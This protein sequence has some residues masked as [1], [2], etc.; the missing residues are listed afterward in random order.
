MKKKS[1]WQSPDWPKC[2]N[3]EKHAG[4]SP[5]ENGGW[6]CQACKDAHTPRSR[7]AYRWGGIRVY[8]CYQEDQG[9]KKEE[10]K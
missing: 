3:N 7:E 9:D 1:A 2:P 5:D 4:M 6:F 10:E 8:A